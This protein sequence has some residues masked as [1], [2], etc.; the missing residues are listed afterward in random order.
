MTLGVAAC[1]TS[2]LAHA[3]RFANERFVCPD[4]SEAPEAYRTWVMETVEA[5]KP[6]MLLPL[7]DLSLGRCEA[8][9]GGHLVVVV[10]MLAQDDVMIGAD[11]GRRSVFDVHVVAAHLDRS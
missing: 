11:D 9:F 4:P 7:T 5:W 1:G 8:E 2:A 3:S 10:N 6:H